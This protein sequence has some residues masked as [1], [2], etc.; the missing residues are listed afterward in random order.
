MLTA[1]SVNGQLEVATFNPKKL[2][3][4]LDLPPLA[5]AD[6]EALTAVEAKTEFAATPSSIALSGLDM[7]LDQTSITGRASVDLAQSVPASSFSL[8]IDKIDV[9][10]YLP[11]ADAGGAQ[12]AKKPEPKAEKPGAEGETPAAALPVGLLRQLNADG[13]IQIGEMKIKGMRLDDVSLTIQA[14]D[15]KID[16][17]PLTSRLYGG[18]L[19]STASL[20]VRGQ[21]PSIRT[22]TKLNTVR[23][24]SLLQDLTGKSLLSGLGSV[25]TALSGQGLDAGSLLRTLDGS[26]HLNVENGAFQGT[27]ILHRIRSTYLTLQGKSAGS[28]GS[29][30]TKFSSLEVA[31]DIAKGKIRKS[32]V[33]LISSL[34]SL[35]GSGQ[36]DLIQRSMDYL[37]K[38]NFDKELSGQY[39]E[40]SGLEGQEIPLDVQGTLTDPRV[41][42]NKESLLKILGQGKISEEVDKGVKKLQEKLG[43]SRSEQEK[44]KDTGKQDAGEQVKDALKGFLGGGSNN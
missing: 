26:L 18:A 41:G 1:P 32:D 38:V 4:R 9:D 5:T 21:T 22:D 30:Q 16:I 33:Q 15:G 7:G 37:L 43:L 40:L 44:S 29:G 2:V 8:Q 28:S 31:A 24:E 13:E 34:F 14:Q 20:D 3:Q 27:D 42:L 10:R 6:P 11:P 17:A 36:L 35:Q 25:Q 39:P 12:A 19:E 23:I